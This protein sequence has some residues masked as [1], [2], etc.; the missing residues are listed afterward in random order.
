MILQRQRF[1]VKPG[2]V[3]EAIEILQ[4]MWKLV[5]PIPH[6]IYRGIAG[7]L[8]T[9]YQDLEFEDFEHRDKWWANMRP[10]VAPLMDKWNACQSTGDNQL[11]RLVE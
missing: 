2:C 3:N 8:N 11:L 4:E 1:T 5:D 9:F 6:R 7:P 10:K